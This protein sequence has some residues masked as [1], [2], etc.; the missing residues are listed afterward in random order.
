MP[1]DTL[2]KECQVLA[3]DPSVV[4]KLALPLKKHDLPRKPLVVSPN[5]GFHICNMGE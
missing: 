4:E 3:S 2:G 5:L 1:D